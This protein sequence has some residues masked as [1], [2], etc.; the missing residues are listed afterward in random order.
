MLANG[1]SSDGDG[2]RGDRECT[3]PNAR[4]PSGN[5]K[6]DHWRAPNGRPAKG[7][8]ARVDLVES[9]AAKAALE[10]AGTNALDAVIF[11]H[12]KTQEE[13]PG[14]EG[15]KMMQGY[16]GHRQNR[17]PSSKVSPQGCLVPQPRRSAAR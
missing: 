9:L 10:E 11:L 2:Y 3:P 17:H 1:Q 8:A 4:V 13:K 16:E 14:G 5:F 7:V 15:T 6:S 12:A